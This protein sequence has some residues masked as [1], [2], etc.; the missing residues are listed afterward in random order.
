MESL[1]ISKERFLEIR[2]WD[3]EE[4][5]E[6]KYSNIERAGRFIYLNRTCFNGLYRVNSKGEFNVPY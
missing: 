3:R 5:Y 4:N 1:Q 6:I 2:M